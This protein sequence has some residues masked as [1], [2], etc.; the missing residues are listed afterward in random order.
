MEEL[1]TRS[2]TFTPETSEEKIREANVQTTLR[3]AR[4][5][6][7]TKETTETEQIKGLILDLREILTEQNYDIAVPFENLDELYPHEITR[8]MRD[9]DHFLQLVKTFTALHV[10]RRVLMK[11]NGNLYILSSVSDVENSFKIFNEIF[12]TTRTS[13]DARI[14]EFYWRFVAGG[15]NLRV[16]ELADN[17]NKVHKVKKTET[18]IRQWLKA[19]NSRGYVDEC[20]DPVDHRAR[21]YNPLVKE[22]PELL[23]NS[24]DSINMMNLSLILKEG[25][26]LW[27]K[28][29]T[30]ERRYYIP[31]KKDDDSFKLSEITE[32]EAERR[33]LS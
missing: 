20:K 33:I 17:Y 23:D 6:L 1:A 13:M 14:L 26:E 3:N 10:H 32:E 30:F 27:L 18:T 31:I 4:P 16:K 28:N 21:L 8:D 24:L 22:K 2:F 11:S 25:L 7:K 29:I 12:E 9:F 19:L 5:W 15:S